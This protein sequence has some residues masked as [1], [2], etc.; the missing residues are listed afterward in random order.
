MQ[1]DEADV[2]ILWRGTA[3]HC[4]P[5]RPGIDDEKLIT[6]RVFTVGLE[7]IQRISEVRIQ[8][9]QAVTTESS[10]KQIGRAMTEVKKRLGEI[11]LLDPVKDLGIKD[12]N[13]DTL[14][15]RAD[16]LTT[17]L[18]K[19]SLSVDFEEADRLR[20]VAACKEKNDLRERARVLR[21]EAKSCQA[22]S[23]KDDLKKMKRVL[24]KLGHVDA[25][26]VIQTKGLSLIHI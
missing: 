10:R 24:K 21:D 2:L 22:I 15:T 1:E 14:L 4:R 8:L 5:V 13:F 25:N 9:P 3:R 17:R 6:W 12:S 16:A 7:S 19:H 26:G 18:G 11:P 23:M 20:L